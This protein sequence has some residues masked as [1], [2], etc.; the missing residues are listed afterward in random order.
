MPSRVGTLSPAVPTASVGFGHATSR[1]QVTDRLA[2]PAGDPATRQRP[3]V[4]RT[5]ASAMARPRPAPPVESVARWNRSKIRARWSSGMPG[6]AS[7]TVSRTRP[8]SSVD[9]HVDPAPGRG[10]LA[11]VVEKD[12]EQPVEPLGW[13]V[14]DVGARVRPEPELELAGLGD[15]PE[16]VHGLGRQDADVDRLCVGRLAGRIEPGEPEEVLD[17]PAHPLALDVDLA[18]RRAVP[19]SLARLGEG[20]ARVRL[21]HRQ[22]RPQLV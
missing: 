18:E 21:D 9:R 2:P 11:G 19:G 10:V 22:R 6:P 7:S 1:R 15:D 16:P 8:P 5:I 14:H 4:V 12:A 3:P 17:E 20:Q 13:H